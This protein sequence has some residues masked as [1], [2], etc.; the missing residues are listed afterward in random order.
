MKTKDRL[1]VKAS[2]AQYTRNFYYATNIFQYAPC[3]VVRSKDSET[4]ARD[5]FWL[6]NYDVFRGNLRTLYHPP[7]H[8]HV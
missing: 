4:T 3:F 6:N 2:L 5:S 1:E 7:P 8:T